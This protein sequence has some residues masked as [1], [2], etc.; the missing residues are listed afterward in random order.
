MCQLS[1]FVIYF[2]GGFKT[3]IVFLSNGHWPENLLDRM[4]KSEKC[5]KIERTH[6]HDVADGVGG[7]YNI[8]I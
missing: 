3:R 4:V 2:W 7:N 8:L 5:R 6:R 1:G